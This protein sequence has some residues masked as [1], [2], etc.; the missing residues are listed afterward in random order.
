MEIFGGKISVNWVK[1]SGTNVTLLSGADCM[2]V[3]KVEE[4]TSATNPVSNSQ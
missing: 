1:Y 3:T 2:L 4:Y